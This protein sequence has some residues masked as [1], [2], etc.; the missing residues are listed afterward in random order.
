MMVVWLETVSVNAIN[1]HF[2][3]SL[4]IIGHHSGEG[5]I[6]EHNTHFCSSLVHGSQDTNVSHTFAHHHLTATHRP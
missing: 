4:S 1:K 2:V 3:C 6:E 5:A